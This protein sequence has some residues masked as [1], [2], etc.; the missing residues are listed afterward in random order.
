MNLWH[1]DAGAFDALARVQPSVRGE[2][3]LV[4]G[5]RLL[6]AAGARVTAVPLALGVLDLSMRGDVASVTARLASHAVAY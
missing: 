3:E 1:L 5:I 6:L 4:D 2:L